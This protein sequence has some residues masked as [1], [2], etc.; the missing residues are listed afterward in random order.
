MSEIKV[1]GVLR[2][3][4]KA[5]VV[6]E[7]MSYVL[8]CLA[9]QGGVLRRVYRRFFAARQGRR[10]TQQSPLRLGATLSTRLATEVA[11]VVSDFG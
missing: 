7:V 11:M 2:R 4:C 5:R 6:V 8:E 9:H 1:V 3:R 10:V